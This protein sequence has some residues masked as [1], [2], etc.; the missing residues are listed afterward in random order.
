MKTARDVLRRQR[1]LAADQ[2]QKLCEVPCETCL[3]EADE[4]ITALA[5]AGFKVLGREPTEE[6]SEGDLTTQA[7]LRHAR[8]CHGT[9]DWD[10]IW[11]TYWDAAEPVKP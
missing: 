7:R 4:D 9:P 2:Y 8:A 6:M 3:R 5:A 1:C 11:S 10:D